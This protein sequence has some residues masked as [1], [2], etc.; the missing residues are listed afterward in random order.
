MP[1]HR[2]SLSVDY[3][4]R[5][6]L[7]LERF[8]FF[9][10]TKSRALWRNKKMGGYSELGPV[11]FGTAMCFHL[12]LISV[13]LNNYNRKYQNLSKNLRAFLPT[14]TTRGKDKGLT[15][16]TEGLFASSQ[17]EKSRLVVHLT[18]WIVYISTAHP[19]LVL[20]PFCF[21]PLC[22]NAPFANLHHF[23]ICIFSFPVWWPFADSFYYA[24]L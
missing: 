5:H 18:A 16:L 24:N 12:Q 10:L 21:T 8:A 11:S 14:N 1:P 23:I 4:T 17:A 20:G 3:G 15:P 22:V 6:S 2:S 7:P 9:F 13:F 19:A